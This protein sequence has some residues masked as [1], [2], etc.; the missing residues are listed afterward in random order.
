M[1]T[2][3]SVLLF[4]AFATAKDLPDVI[5]PVDVTDE[6][7]IEEHV[8]TDEEYWQKYRDANMWGKQIWGGFYQGLYGSMSD[9]EPTNDCFGDWIIDD[10]I[11]LSEF[12][13]SLKT[14]WMVDMDQ[15]SHAAYDIVDL[16]FL[17][18]KYCHFRHAIWD[19]KQFCSAEENCKGG[20][21]IDHLQQNAF[22]LIT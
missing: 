9:S 18:D 12:K 15:A 1:K 21:I 17:N 7:M 10:L 4:A 5:A 16:L 20:D 2:F 6:D 19:I 8:Q 14:S 3:A 13:Q 22:P 11:N